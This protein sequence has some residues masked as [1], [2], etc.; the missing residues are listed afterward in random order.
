MRCKHGQTQRVLFRAFFGNEI[1]EYCIRSKKLFFG[2]IVLVFEHIH[3][4]LCLRSIVLGNH[5]RK[6]M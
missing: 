3:E 1:R 2:D 5:L 4:T 6:K